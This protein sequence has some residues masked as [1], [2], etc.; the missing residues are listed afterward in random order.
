MN[1]QSMEQAAIV[2]S[3]SGDESPAHRS[4]PAGAMNPRSGTDRR[5]QALLQV[6][7]LFD[8]VDVEYCIINGYERLYAAEG[9]GSSDLDCIVRPEA[10]P[11]RIATLLY[12]NAHRVGADVVGWE[13]APNHYVALALREPRGAAEVARLDLHAGYERDGRRLF[14]AAD[15]LRSRQRRDDVWVPAADLDF[16]HYVVRKILKGSLG[17]RRTRRLSAH[18]TRDSAGCERRL[19]D[20][21]DADDARLIA[22][23]ARSG[24]WDRVTAELPRLR[25][26]LLRRFVRRH[27]WLVLRA[28]MAGVRRRVRGLGAPR[29][30]LHVVLLGPDGV[31]KSTVIEALPDVLAPVFADGVEMDTPAGLVNRPNTPGTGPHDKAPRGLLSS[32]AKA[33]YWFLYYSP[34]YYLTTHPPRDQAKLHLSHR[35]LV[36]A[37]VDPKRYRYGGP[38]WLLRVLWRVAIKPDLI[39]LLD[40]P[41]PVIQA[42][43]REVAP[44]ETERQVYAYRD[45]VAT[46]PNGYIVDAAQP[47]DAVVADVRDAILHCM[48]RR[49]ARRLGLAAE[50][51]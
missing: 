41:A 47:V 42:R 30:G 38:R 48:S 16:V 23:A 37:L 34:G 27:P 4:V 39:I 17:E 33:I 40:A 20:F 44:E 24:D 2:E 11:S 22:D 45:L 31:G 18:F 7:T 1:A 14:S 29:R 49:V 28:R 15:V 50:A 5:Q 19:A 25:T 13:G 35:Y 9:M 6:C 26:A 10:V 46:L 12:R 8:E 32:L 51:R 21:W 43:K 3:H 36:D